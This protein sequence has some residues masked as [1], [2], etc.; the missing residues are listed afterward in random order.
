MKKNQNP[1]MPARFSHFARVF[2]A[3]SVVIAIMV[4][5]LW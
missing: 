2:G 4:V 1:A 5:F 3:L